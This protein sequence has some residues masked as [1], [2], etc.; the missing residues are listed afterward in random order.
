[1]IDSSPR[2][3]APR[4]AAHGGVEHG[5]ASWRE[6]VGES[7]RRERVDRAHADHDMSR[8]GAPN[9]AVLA[10]DDGLGLR[11]RLHHADRALDRGGYTLGGI[12]HRGAA[13]TRASPPG[14]RVHDGSAARLSWQSL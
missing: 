14:D 5:D 9:N 13:P 8:P 10:R 4:A 12:D 11:G 1:M 6:L 7:A 2:S 3:C